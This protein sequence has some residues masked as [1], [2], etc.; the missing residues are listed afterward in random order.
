M[1]ATTPATRPTAAGTVVA[2]CNLLSR[3]VL[4]GWGATLRLAFIVVIGTACLIALV[5]L[6]AWPGLSTLL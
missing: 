1:A 3:V 5:A 6:G 4:A 2:L